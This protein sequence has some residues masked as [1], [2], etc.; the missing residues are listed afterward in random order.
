MIILYENNNIIIM[1]EIISGSGFTLLPSNITYV[2]FGEELTLMCETNERYLRWNISIPR[3]GYKGSRLVSY[4]G[5]PVFEPLTTNNTIFSIFRL[6]TTPL[7]ATMMINNVVAD[8]T[9]FCT[10]L[11]TSVANLLAT[12]IHVIRMNGKE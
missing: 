12:D 4:G 2:C 1:I 11:S 9:V 3:D 5:T 8:M 7:I 10:E 6:S